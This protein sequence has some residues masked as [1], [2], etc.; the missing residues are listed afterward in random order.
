VSKKSFKEQM[1]NYVLFFPN[2]FTTGN[3]FCGFYSI[4]NAINGNYIFA[5]YLI[6]L[7][8]VFDL[9]DGR[10]ARLVNSSSE[11]GREYD[12]LADMVS[13]G[14]APVLLSYFYALNS[15]YRLGWLA[16]FLFLACG[17]LR[18]AKFNSI[19]K[20][21]DSNF[22]TGLPIPIA[23][24]TIATYILFLNNV[25][26]NYSNLVLIFLVLILGFLMV[27][28]IRYRSYKN[29]FFNIKQNFLT[30]MIL[31]ILFIVFVAIRPEIIMFFI[32]LFYIL[33]NPVLNMFYKNK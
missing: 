16:C 9:V 4:I 28:T 33:I 18:L 22:F 14:V 2:V 17:T 20:D 6:L 1:E 25:S 3:L 7:A 15:I 29:T 19:Y 5:S 30:K 23:A 32:S 8:G 10:I 12:S 11:F 27:S 24:V 21:N 31:F 13:F 26:F